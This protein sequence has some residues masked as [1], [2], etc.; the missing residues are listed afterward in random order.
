MY[1]LTF[2]S[3]KGYNKGTNSFFEHVLANKVL[4][5]TASTIIILYNQSISLNFFPTYFKKCTVVLF[6]KPRD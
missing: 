3:N 6:Y 5:N 4:K 1:C 2:L